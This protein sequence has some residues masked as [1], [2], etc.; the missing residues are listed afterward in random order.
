V[1]QERLAVAFPVPGIRVLRL[2]T[3]GPDI[4]RQSTHNPARRVL[5]DNLAYIIYTSGSTGTPK[6]IQIPHAALAN[7]LFAMSQE[8]GLTQQDSI[9]AVTTLSFDIA[10]LELFL[11]L[12][13]GAHTV[14]AGRE[15]ALDGALLMDSLTK[16]RATMMQATPTTWRLLIERGWKGGK[17]F[18]I[19]CGGEDLPRELAD[20]LMDRGACLWNLYGPT[21]TTIWST[22]YQFSGRQERV[23]IGRPIA[24]TQIYLLDAR[25][26]PV[27]IGV[28]GD[29]YIGGR[30]LARSY[31]NRPDA[32]AEK[33]VPNPFGGVL[34]E[35][36]YRTGDV[37]RFLPSGNLEILGRSDSQIKIRGFRIESGEIEAVLRQHPAVQQAI[38]MAREDEEEIPQKGK[39]LVAFVIP[40]EQHTPTTSS[41]YHFLKR[42]LPEYMVP[43]AFML[44]KAFP[45]TPNGKVDRQALPAVDTAR[46]ALE[47][48]FLAP[49][50]PVEEVLAGIWADVLGLERVGVQDN[51]FAL[52]GHSLLATQVVSRINE[53]FQ[54][55][56]P[57]IALFEASTV[58][59]LSTVVLNYPL[60]EGKVEATAQLLLQIAKMSDDEVEMRLN[61]AKEATL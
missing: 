45:L 2:D 13:V 47:E 46:P 10:V 1:T 3:D 19:L 39:Y 33:F 34:G 30:G 41:L 20:Q 4:E 7:F 15:S 51:F 56:L 26:S 61:K 23:S 9:L 53:A 58:A 17:Q 50:N 57:L 5:P 31:L 27:P 52:G 28:A 49:R 36:L 37:A 59:E 38:V 22:V 18:K 55:D 25:L 14:I 44:V 43:S 24:N 21:E 40:H 11:P 42:K 35:R 12:T 60:G 32:T 29:V 54:F 16:A 8:P 6:G 48:A